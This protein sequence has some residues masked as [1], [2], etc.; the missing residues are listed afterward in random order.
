[1]DTARHQISGLEVSAQTALDDRDAGWMRFR[2]PGFVCCHCKWPAGLRRRGRGEE[3]FFFHYAHSPRNCPLLVE[4]DTELDFLAGDEGSIRGASL[5]D[6]LIEEV[7]KSFVRAL[8]KMTPAQIDLQ[9]VEFLS[10]GI[11]DRRVNGRADERMNI[12]VSNL[13]Q[14]LYHPQYIVLLRWMCA[15][16]ANRPVHPETSEPFWETVQEEF[17]SS[18][19]AQSWY[20]LVLPESAPISR[21]E[22]PTT[23]LGSHGEHRLTYSSFYGRMN[24]FKLNHARIDVAEVYHY[25]TTLIIESASEMQIGIARCRQG[26]AASIGAIRLHQDECRL[27]LSEP[28]AIILSPNYSLQDRNVQLRPFLYVLPGISS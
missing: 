25:P 20:N 23:R 9:V 10:Y 16:L 26:S 8:G 27:T 21:T 3:P 1:M 15:N 4:S 17:L 24:C 11:Q 18:D 2:P 7:N 28:E 14:A 13:I 6:V 22:C 12:F 5:A 19:L